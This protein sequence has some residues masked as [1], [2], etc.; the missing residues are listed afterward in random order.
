MASYQ[1]EYANFPAKG[2]ITL[3]NFQDVT[4][5]VAALVNEIESLRQAGKFGE[6][7]KLERENSDR[8]INRAVGSEWFRTI[9][10]EVHNTQIFARA[11]Q[12]CVHSGADEPIANENDVW[13]GG[14]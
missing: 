11:A 9:E 8:L 4:D 3:H 7:A 2:L 5:E 13:I 14:I 1:Y 10:E 12:Q 6:A